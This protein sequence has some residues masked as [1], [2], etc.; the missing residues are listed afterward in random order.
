MKNKH[1]NHL[2]RFNSSSAYAC[3]ALLQISASIFKHIRFSASFFI[4]LFIIS[5]AQVVTPG[6]GKK[7]TVPPKVV[8]YS[9][10]SAQLNFNSK[11]IEISF[12]EYIQLKDLNSQLIISP[13]LEK[14]PDI[15]VKNR[16]LTID[17]DKQELKPNTTYSINFGNSLQDINEGNPKDNFKYIFSTGSFIDSLVST[18]RVR[19]AFD[20]KPEKGVLAML[21]TDMSDSAVYK[22]QPDYFAKT[23]SDGDFRIDNVKEGEYKLVAVKD[24]NSNYKFDSETESIGFYDSLIKL[25]PPLIIHRD[26]ITKSND[27]LV[28]QRDT[29]N[30]RSDSLLNTKDTLSIRTDSLLN[31][32]DTLRRPSG[33]LIP[34]KKSITIDLFQEQ[35]TKIFIKKYSLA[36]YGKVVLVFSQGSDSLQITNMAVDLKGV[37]EFVDFSKNRDTLIY[38]VKNYHKDSLILQ[39]SNGHTVIDT[40]EFKMTKL[41]DAL[42]SKKNGLKLRLTNNFSGNQNVDL[43]TDLKFNFSQPI[44]I[45]DTSCEFVFI[46]DSVFYKNKLPLEFFKDSSLYSVTL[47]LKKDSV[48]GQQAPA[49]IRHIPLKESTRYS[50]SI[51]PGTFT[52]IFGLP[53]DSLKIDFKTRE[54]KYYGNL[55]LTINAPAANGQYIIQLLDE[56]ESLVRES[57]ITGSEIIN[58]EYLHPKKYKLK[59]ILDEN[60][61]LKWDSGNYLEKTHAEKVIYNTEDL[62]IRSNWDAEIEWK[63]TITN[64]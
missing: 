20:H 24:L 18:G 62:T 19:N 9:P 34:K 22:S 5:C 54:L 7:D 57:I 36:S 61:N 21:Y 23:G 6:G 53:N 28:N 60:C 45:V 64:N 29:L 8:S 41:E 3:S 33:N 30:I 47:G 39:V 4:S 48:K 31:P 35:A 59:I 63:I 1:N 10:D 51:Q 13:P 14:I 56:K 43:N 40:L 16:T 49:Y 27:T 42:K 32:K 11:T 58:Y 46:E 38:W 17:M 12:D 55:K 44:A 25:T 26:T 52:D 2:D 50:L 37:Q 15:N